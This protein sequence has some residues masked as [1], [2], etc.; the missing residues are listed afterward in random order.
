MSAKD[1]IIEPEKHEIAV[2]ILRRS[3]GG[4]YGEISDDELTVLA[5]D[6]F[7]ELDKEEAAGQA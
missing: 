6:R 5:L 2:E 4:D 7:I 1:A 3:T